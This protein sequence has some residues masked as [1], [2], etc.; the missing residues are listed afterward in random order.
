M[1]GDAVPRE[2]VCLR[3]CPAHQAWPLPAPAAEKHINSHTNR[4]SSRNTS[5]VHKTTLILCY[6]ANAT[7]LIYKA[8]AYNELPQCCIP[9][10]WSAFFLESTRWQRGNLNPTLRQM[11]LTKTLPQRAFFLHSI[12]LKQDLIQL[13]HPP[14]K[15]NVGLQ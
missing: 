15:L 13:Q 2:V 3:P 7:V 4:Q 10:L 5:N 1:C 9:Q 6:N 12:I 8:A 14:V 11:T